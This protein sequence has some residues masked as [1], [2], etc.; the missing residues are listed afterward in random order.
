MLVGAN[1][2]SPCQRA[3]K[4]L[5]SRRSPAMVLAFAQQIYHTS[6]NLPSVLEE[7]SN[8][9]DTAVCLIKIYFIGKYQN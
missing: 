7:Q 4:L 2:H 3:H 6:L 5:P 1:L 8:S 9:T